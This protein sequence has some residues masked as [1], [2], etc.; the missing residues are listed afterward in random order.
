MRCTATNA[1][2]LTVLLSLTWPAFVAALA[3]AQQTPT[4]SIVIINAQ[5][6][7]GTGAPFRSATVRVTRDRIAKIGSFSPNKSDELIDAKG[8]VLA[9]GFIDMHNHSNDHLDSDPLAES[10]ISQGITTMILGA[11]GA[12]P[13]PIAPWL[14]AREKNP[15]SLNLAMMVG[16][17][18]LRE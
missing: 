2:R 9:P 5:I 13:W 11:D 10:Q 17:A 3:F 12:S 1:C 18:T 7:D 15:A 8:L 4:K 16:H 14:E 6:A